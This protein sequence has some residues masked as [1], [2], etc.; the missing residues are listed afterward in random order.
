MVG[1]GLELL[2][3]QYWAVFHV[4]DV[5]TYFIHTISGSYGHYIVLAWSTEHSV[6][7]IDGLI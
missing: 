2:V 4:I 1:C 5:G 7:Q 6:N 3:E